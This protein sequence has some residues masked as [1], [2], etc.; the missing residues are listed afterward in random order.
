VLCHGSV[1][2]PSTLLR[3]WCLHCRCTQSYGWPLHWCDSHCLCLSR[4]RGRERGAIPEHLSR[5]AACECFHGWLAFLLFGFVR[6]EVTF[7]PTC[8][9]L[10]TNRPGR[11]SFS[12][13]FVKADLHSQLGLLFELQEG[14]A[15]N[16]TMFM[17]HETEVMQ[18]LL[19]FLTHSERLSKGSFLG[20]SFCK[21]TFLTLLLSNT[22][23]TFVKV[24]FHSQPVVSL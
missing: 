6:L 8:T 15:F 17:L 1:V 5:H 18:G 19:S 13:V 2:R 9:D 22:G 3:C 23:M 16:P 11:F 24:G 7:I 10:T 12:P 21:V 4:Q 20:T 14:V